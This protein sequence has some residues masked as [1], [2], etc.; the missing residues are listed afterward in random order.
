VIEQIETSILF[1][2][3]SVAGEHV[4]ALFSWDPVVSFVDVA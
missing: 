2:G 3:S 1:T 4:A